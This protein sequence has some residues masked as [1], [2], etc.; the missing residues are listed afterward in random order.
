MTR[1]SESN[2]SKRICAY[3]AEPATHEVANEART[4][5]GYCCDEPTHWEWLLS[6][7]EREDRET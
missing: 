1:L 6:S 7:V 4:L 2:A 3:C 5:V